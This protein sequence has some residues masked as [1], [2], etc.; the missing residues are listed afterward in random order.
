[1]FYLK[2]REIIHQEIITKIYYFQDIVKFG[3]VY[4]IFAMGFA[5]V[6]IFI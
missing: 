3:S 5:E 2:P 4:F 1:M 6:T